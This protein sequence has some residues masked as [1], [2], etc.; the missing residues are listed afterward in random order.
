MISSRDVYYRWIVV[1]GRYEI[2]SPDETW[3][4]VRAESDQAE[5]LICFGG[6]KLLQPGARPG[7]ETNFVVAKIVRTFFTQ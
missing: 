6:S 3:L 4:F 2:A 5:K 7:S 1:G